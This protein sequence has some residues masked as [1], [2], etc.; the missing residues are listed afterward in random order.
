[1]LRTSHHRRIDNAALL[2]Y[3]GKTT[4]WLSEKQE[5]KYARLRGNDE[6]ERT[7]NKWSVLESGFNRDIWDTSMPLAL[8]FGSSNIPTGKSEMSFNEKYQAGESYSDPVKAAQPGLLDDPVSLATD[9]LKD[10]IGARGKATLP[11]LIGLFKALSSDGPS[12]DRKG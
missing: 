6:S 5:A 4:C 7:A 2:S 8:V 3:Q 12:D 9:V 1:M 11:E 10:Y